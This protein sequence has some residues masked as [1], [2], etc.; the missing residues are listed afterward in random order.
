MLLMAVPIVGCA[1]N[2][3]A[4]FYV[5]GTNGQPVSAV[6]SLIPSTGEP[7]IRPG[8]NPADDDIRMMED[9]FAQIGYASFVGPSQ[10]PTLAKARA[11]A[12]KAAVVLIYNSNPQSVTQV[13]PVPDMSFVAE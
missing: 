10:N 11:R 6:T 5:S 1:T 8:S 9:G 13:S 2:P 12:L 4:Q 3:Y 7:E